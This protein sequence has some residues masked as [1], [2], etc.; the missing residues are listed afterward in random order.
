MT[1]T[2]AGGA[3][4]RVAEGDPL[5]PDDALK[6]GQRSSI[7]TAYRDH[8]PR[9]LRF[10]SR[11]TADDVADDVVQ[12]SFVSVMAK[13]AEGRLR[14]RRL[15]SYLFRVA[16]NVEIDLG[17]ADQRHEHVPLE[18]VEGASPDQIHTADQIAALEARDMLNR[19]ELVMQRLRPRTR[20]IFL[21]HR[22]DGYTYGEIAARTGLSVKG[23]EKHMTL[24]IAAVHKGMNPRGCRSRTTVRTRSP[25]PHNAG[26]RECAG[27][28]RRRL[29]TA[30]AH[31]T[32]RTPRTALRIATCRPTGIAQ[33]S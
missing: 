1:L 4:V 6:V 26:L 2:R 33:N 18:V 25:R 28:T 5:P 7:E 27:Q 29:P 17:R 14:I 22:I 11:R 16:R 32:T 13:Q 10:L 3:C 24:A 30:F 8:R 15:D 12:Q 9:L 21:A 20:E 31:G 23:V 19:L